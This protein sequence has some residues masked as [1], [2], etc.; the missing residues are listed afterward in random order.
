MKNFKLYYSKRGGFLKCEN[1]F[2]IYWK[3]D[4]CCLKS[5]SLDIQG[6]CKECEYVSVDEKALSVFRRNELQKYN[7]INEENPVE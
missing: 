2:C 6:M 5:V 7:L 3:D 4:A 1:V